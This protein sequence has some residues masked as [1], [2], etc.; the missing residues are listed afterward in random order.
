MWSG[1]RIEVLGRIHQ[2]LY[3]SDSFS[4]IDFGRHLEEVSNNLLA[5]SL[6]PQGEEIRLN[7]STEPFFCDIE[8]AIPLGL[9]ANELVSNSFKH[10]FPPGSSGTISIS[11]RHIK[12]AD[13]GAMV[14]MAVAD[15]GVGINSAHAL[16]THGSGLGMRLIEALASQINADLSVDPCET[17]SCFTVTLILAADISKNLSPSA[18]PLGWDADMAKI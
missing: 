9:I 2:Q 3:K 6:R 12:M 7:I 4:L 13:G 16:E 5:F 17:G 14:V 15:D 11:L 10:A 8:T 18:S 1:R